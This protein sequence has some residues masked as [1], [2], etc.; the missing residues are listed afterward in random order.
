MVWMR[1]RVY[2]CL[3]QP[4]I[5]L[6]EEE[7]EE[8]ELHANS[9]HP[10]YFHRQHH[11]HWSLMWGVSQT[12]FSCCCHQRRQLLVRPCTVDQRDKLQQHRMTDEQRMKVH[13][14]HRPIGT[15]TARASPVQH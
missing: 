12:P 2:A 10:C 7:E 8:E 6:M 4:A 5:L 1:V 11:C 15:R 3:T 9:W 13:S 14:V